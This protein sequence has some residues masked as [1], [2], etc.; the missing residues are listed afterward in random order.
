MCRYPT[1]NTEQGLCDMA[2]N[3]LEWVE[4]DWH[5]NYTGA[6]S[7]GSAWVDEPRDPRFRVARGGA[8]LN[9][10]G[11]DGGVTVRVSFRAQVSKSGLNYQGFRLARSVAR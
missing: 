10:T 4:D 3:V 11:A 9:A 2:G 6:P 1:G 8:W 5:A 7:D